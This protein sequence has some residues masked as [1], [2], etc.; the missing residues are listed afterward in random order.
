MDAV[1][2]DH[3]SAAGFELQHLIKSL[4]QQPSILT[5]NVAQQLKDVVPSKLHGDMKSRVAL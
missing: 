3:E 1:E 4:A 2:Q 5:V